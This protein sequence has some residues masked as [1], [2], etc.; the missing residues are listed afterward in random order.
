MQD[1]LKFNYVEGADKLLKVEK[2]QTE[3]GIN[4]FGIRVKNIVPNSKDTMFWFKYAKRP[5]DDSI[6]IG[7]DIEL[8]AFQ[9][10]GQSAWQVNKDGIFKIFTNNDIKYVAP[11][12]LRF[13]DYLKTMSLQ[14][15]NNMGEGST[16]KKRT[17]VNKYT[18]LFK[19]IKFPCAAALCI[20]AACYSYFVFS[21]PP[22]TLNTSDVAVE[23][24]VSEEEQKE[25]KC[26]YKV[27]SLGTNIKMKLNNKNVKVVGSI[28]TGKIVDPLKMV[29]SDKN[30]IARATDEYNIL[31]T[32]NHTII[33]GDNVEAVMHGDFNVIGKS[34][35]IYDGENENQIAVFKR[36]LSGLGGE[37]TDMDGNVLAS[38]KRYP[39]RF[40]FTITINDNDTFSDE[41]IV[42]ILSSFVSDDIAD[43]RTSK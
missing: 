14:M 38:Y 37:L 29:D 16:E 25:I 17:F 22:K 2:L 19:K 30:V 8:L 21:Q 24:V 15:I 33:V 11:A 34:Y 42:M 12:Q 1:L 41:A 10:Q 36:S 31:N 9:V 13:I 7:V 32:N 4:T 35:K 3:R 20:I 43:N 23:T 18:G 28:F 26:D 27:M 39:A 6:N 5:S 40:D